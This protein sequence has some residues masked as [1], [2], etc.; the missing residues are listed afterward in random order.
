MGHQVRTPFSPPG[1]HQYPA[2]TG[3]DEGPSWELS[4][5]LGA[6][7]P[8][9]IDARLLH[10]VN[11]V[12]PTAPWCTDDA[13]IEEKE[14]NFR[15]QQSYQEDFDT[16]MNDPFIDTDDHLQNQPMEPA[17][18]DRNHHINTQTYMGDLHQGTATPSSIMQIDQN[19]TNAQTH[20][21]DLHQ[22]AAMPSS[23]MQIDQNHTN[24]QTHVG[25]LHQGAAMPPSMMQIYQN[26]HINAQ[27]P[28]G[29]DLRRRAVMRSSMMQLQQHQQNPPHGLNWQIQVNNG[30][31][32]I[33]RPAPTNHT[34]PIAPMRR[35]SASAS[36]P[37]HNL[38]QQ[39]QLSQQ[40]PPQ[41]HLPRQ[42]L[43]QQHLQQQ[44]VSENPRR[45][46]RRLDAG[47]E[48]RREAQPP[49]ANIRSGAI[50][51]APNARGTAAAAA[52]TA[53]TDAARAAV[54]SPNSRWTCR[55]L[56]RRFGF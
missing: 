3:Q 46:R 13:T 41:Q 47:E 39:Q 23:M 33:V 28:V 12:D 15:Q 55:E 43:Q 48:A 22:G 24:A 17:F 31:G 53:T 56:Q 16:V 35:S 54:E 38:Q 37:T 18:I 34:R 1:L 9:T 50:T 29:G 19:H 40:H 2:T 51:G 36:A 8:A 30:H 7:Q 11:G 32:N 6:Q 44:H 45:K 52:A 4:S 14:R 10:H 42:N 25:D 20:V 5:G 26:H 49:P 27:T 21:G